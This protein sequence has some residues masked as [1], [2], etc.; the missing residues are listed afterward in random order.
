[1]TSCILWQIKTWQNIYM[2]YPQP[3]E[4]KFFPANQPQTLQAAVWMLY[5]TGFLGLISGLA[6]GGYG[7]IAILL[8]AGNLAGGYGISNEKK[9]GYFAGVGV[10]VLSLILALSYGLASVNII[11]IIF[12]VAL[13]VLLLHPMS[14]TYYKTWFK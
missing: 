1:M 5:L 2:A 10:S 14:R 4:R 3:V 9:W 11:N 13:I 6:Y 7:L 8:L 12:T